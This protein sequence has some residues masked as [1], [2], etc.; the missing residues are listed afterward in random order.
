MHLA[1]AVSVGMCSPGFHVLGMYSPGFHVLGMCS[2]G[3]HVLGQLGLSRQASQACT[4]LAGTVCIPTLILCM[5][6]HMQI[7]ADN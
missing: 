7:A 2:P 1:A 6:M 5:D 3:F 4:V